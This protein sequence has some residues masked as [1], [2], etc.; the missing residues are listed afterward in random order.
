[1][2]VIEGSNI[3]KHLRTYVREAHT[4]E[5]QIKM[6]Y[7]LKLEIDYSPRQSIYSVKTNEESFLVAAF[8]EEEAIK[9][10][11]ARLIRL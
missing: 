7:I 8:T 2:H 3:S 10:V 11:E 9:I 1:M 5:R 4:E 6:N